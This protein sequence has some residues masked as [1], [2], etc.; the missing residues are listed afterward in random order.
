MFAVW[1]AYQVQALVSINQIG[2][3][4][5]GWTLSGALIGYSYLAKDSEDSQPEKKFKSK[6]KELRGKPMKAS[7]ALVGFLGLFLGF[8]LTA[9]PMN[10][11]IRYRDASNRGDLNAMIA[12]TNLLGSTEFHK[13]LV[14]DFAMRNNLGM[15]VKNLATELV[16][17]YPRSF[18]GW[19]V[20]SVAALS[21]PEERFAALE[22]ARELDPF[23]PDLR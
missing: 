21:T 22:K 7:H 11:D 10:A 4:I 6:S 18:F 20:L 15:E 16:R 19:R 3:G 5:W 23:N 8:V 1:I 17:E 2:V 12:A 14:L 9:I 13:E